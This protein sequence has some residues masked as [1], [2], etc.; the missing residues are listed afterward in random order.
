MSSILLALFGGGSS[1][2]S[3]SYTVNVGSYQSGFNFFYYGFGTSPTAFGSVTPSVFAS[4]NTS[5]VN[6]GGT[7]HTSQFYTANIIYFTISGSSPQSLFNSMSVGGRVF[8]SSSAGFSAGSNTT[9]YWIITGTTD[10]FAANVGNNLIVT[11]A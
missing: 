11:F 3:G 6:L 2:Q 7:Y 5:I 10:P 9:W 4:S 1:V 8:T